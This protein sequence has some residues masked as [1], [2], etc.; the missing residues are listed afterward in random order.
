MYD[1]TL[2]LTDHGTFRIKM[3]DNGDVRNKNKNLWDG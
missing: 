3:E 1:L 2:A